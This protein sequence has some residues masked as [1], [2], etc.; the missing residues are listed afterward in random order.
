MELIEDASKAIESK[1]S[2]GLKMQSLGEL[3]AFWS[4]VDTV[5]SRREHV[6]LELPSFS[7]VAIAL[8]HG[9][10]TASSRR[11]AVT[12]TWNRTDGLLSR[13]WMLLEI[14]L[15]MVLHGESPRKWSEPSESVSSR[16][17]LPCR[18][19]PAAQRRPCLLSKRLVLTWLLSLG[20]LS[21]SAN[22]G[23]DVE[24]LSMVRIEMGA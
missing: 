7:W 21:S 13:D 8:N 20:Y 14:E 23:V 3:V 9:K 12:E 24:M 10:R 5:M 18:A 11:D 22:V 4:L 6:K 1:G 15:V 16:Y 2:L 19:L 17:Y